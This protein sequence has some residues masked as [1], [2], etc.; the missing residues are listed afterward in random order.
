MLVFTM[1]TMPLNQPQ[2][3]DRQDD[4][5]P[6]HSLAKSIMENRKKQF[7]YRLPSNT[8]PRVYIIELDPDFLGEKFTFNGNG[9]IIFEV[10]RP[11]STVTL[12]RSNQMDIDNQATEL[13]DESG[14]VKKPI[15]QDWNPANNFFSIKFESKL[16]VGNYSLKMSWTGRDGNDDW[17]SPRSG[18]YRAVDK[19]ENGNPK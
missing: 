8:A 6:V 18:F 5:R 10:L 12:H 3:Q 2:A 7:E 1:A 13:I 4:Q 19:D 17:F 9:T 14:N 15:S 11:T 16:N